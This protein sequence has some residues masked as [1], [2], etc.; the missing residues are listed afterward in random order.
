MLFIKCTLRLTVGLRGPRVDKKVWWGVLC[1]ADIG[2][3]FLPLGCAE[4]ARRTL[5]RRT[6]RRGDSNAG[7]LARTEG[8]SHC[9]RLG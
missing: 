4:R 7:P 1:K 5:A 8:L 3:V 6:R 9:G 2:T